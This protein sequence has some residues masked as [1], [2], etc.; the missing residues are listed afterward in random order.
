MEIERKTKE[1][2]KAYYIEQLGKFFAKIADIPDDEIKGLPAVHIP[3]LGF[4]DEMPEIAFYG[5]ETSTWGSMLELRNRYIKDP[6]SAYNYLTKDIFTPSKVISW[7]QPRQSI[8]FKYVIE[9][10]ASVYELTTKKLKDEEELKKHSFIWGNIMSLERYSVSAKK[11]GV[12]LETHKRAYDA[13]AILNKLPNGHL[14]PT[15]IVRACRPK[16]LFILY[17]DF[18]FGNWLKNEFGID[19]DKINKHLYYVH[20]KETDT[21]VFKLPHPVFI[22]RRIGWYKSIKEVLESVRIKQTY[23]SK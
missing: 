17:W 18:N 16:L 8:F 15:Y 21:H 5:M 7:A 4:T 19:K 6:E 1:E 12:K 10:L 11:N 20:I 14:G 13:S 9:L 22:N 3:A 2:V 23:N